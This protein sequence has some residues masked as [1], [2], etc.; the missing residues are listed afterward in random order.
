MTTGSARVSGSALMRRRTSVAVDAR[1][2]QIEQHECGQRA[3]GG[4]EQLVD[5]FAAVTGNANGLMDVGAAERAN[6]QL[7]IVRIVVHQQDGLAHD[8]CGACS[9][10]KVK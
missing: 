5:G 1:Q 2:F 10:S 6:R 4:A 8:Q 9:G 7:D 3:S